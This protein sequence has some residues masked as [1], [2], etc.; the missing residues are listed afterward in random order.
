MKHKRLYQL[1]AAAFCML[2]FIFPFDLAAQKRFQHDS[3][4]YTSYPR[5]LTT[6]FYLSKK[7]T[8]LTFPAL[9][10][11][12]DLSYTAN[13]NLTMGVGATYNNLSLNLAYGFGFLNPDDEKGKTKSID[14]ELHV[15]PAK[16]SID[17]LGIRHKGLYIDPKGYAVLNKNNFYYRPDAVMM[18]AGISAYRV[19]N[20]D[21]FSYNAAMIQSE[22]QKKSAGSLLYGGEVYYGSIKGDSSL[23]P[24]AKE[25]LFAQAGIDKMQFFTIGA[26]GGYAYTLVVKEHF[27]A[28]A[29]LIANLDVNFSIEE[30]SAMRNK[31]TAVTP[32]FIYKAAIGY[33]NDTW[34][35]SANWAA[36]DL[37]VKGASSDKAYAIPT[38]NYRLILAKRI[39][40]KRK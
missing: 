22:R 7:Y 39:S 19:P 23:V 15:Y 31:N 27:F 13:T 33:N 17:V 12:N 14:L 34:I 5:K 32:S 16:W 24:K 10:K 38:G 9:S 2:L 25:N 3:N 36:N 4:Y 37:W 8:S 20:N 11:E 18:L 40:M 21:R 26:G 35:V 6:R 1:L 28:M 30:S 29:S